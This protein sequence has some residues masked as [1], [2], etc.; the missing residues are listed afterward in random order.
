MLAGSLPN[1]N[2]QNDGWLAFFLLIKLF[3]FHL[4]AVQLLWS[5]I[6]DFS[7]YYC[8]VPRNSTFVCR[9]DKNFLK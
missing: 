1:Y 4:P 7:I 2:L 5:L 6:N 8:E 9:T 3:A